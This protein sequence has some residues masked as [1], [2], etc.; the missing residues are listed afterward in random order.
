MNHDYYKMEKRN[1]FTNGHLPEWKKACGSDDRSLPPEYCNRTFNH[2]YDI[3]NLLFNF[4]F[5]FYLKASSKEELK[6]NKF[7]RKQM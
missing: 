4:C 7:E 3:V 1:R 5:F 2:V 6:C